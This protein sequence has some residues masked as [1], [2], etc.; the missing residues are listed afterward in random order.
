[1]TI[2][3]KS[4][5]QGEKKTWMKKSHINCEML[6]KIIIYSDDENISVKWILLKKY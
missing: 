5:L 3:D 4:V 2:I 6:S 1:M